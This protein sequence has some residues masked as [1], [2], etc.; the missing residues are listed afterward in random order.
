MRHLSEIELCCINLSILASLSR[1][2]LNSLILTFIHIWKNSSSSTT[3]ITTRARARDVGTPRYR[4]RKP[5]LFY[6]RAAHPGSIRARTRGSTWRCTGENSR[7]R[8]VV[9]RRMDSMKESQWEQG[10]SLSAR[11]RW[12]WRACALPTP[13]RAHT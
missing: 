6:P 11:V 10:G 13:P 9:S 7:S 2:S 1:F 5:L 4:K 12:P 8:V 3:V